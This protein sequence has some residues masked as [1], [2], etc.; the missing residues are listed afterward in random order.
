MSEFT[1]TLTEAQR[2]ALSFAALCEAEALEKG[3]E[4][5]EP[6]VQ[7]A[8]CS[9]YQ[10]RAILEQGMAAMSRGY[11]V[12]ALHQQN[13]GLTMQEFAD[14][15]GL[16]LK[17]AVTA[18]RGGKILGA[19]Q[20]GR[21][22]RWHVY[23]P[24]KLMERPRSY[25][26]SAGVSPEAAAEFPGLLPCGSAVAVEAGTGSGQSGQPVPQVEA[27]GTRPPAS[28]QAPQGRAEGC[29]MVYRSPEVQSVLCVLREAAARQFR[30]GLHYLRLDAHEFAQL[31]AAL[32]S[33]RSRT[34]K[35]VG[36]GLLPVGLLRASDT[37]WQKMQ[38]MSRE[39]RLL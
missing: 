5:H 35:L 15:E 16:T 37:V 36:R 26:R 13:G 14:K 12:P 3:R 21:S 22:K 1:F 10:A 39:G 27:E 28:Q 8:V 19:S 24:A 38:A 32:G 4:K 20:D 11:D 25:M 31:Y 30:E 23:P 17:Q 9:L 7:Q 18:A 34:R 2:A 33:E 29:S 6:E